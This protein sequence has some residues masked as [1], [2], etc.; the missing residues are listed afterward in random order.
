MGYTAMKFDPF[1]A[2]G[3]EMSRAELAPRREG[4]GEPCATRRART[5]TC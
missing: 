4:G 2:G 3:R 1:G 5:S